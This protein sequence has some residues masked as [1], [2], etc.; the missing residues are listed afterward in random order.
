MQVA[1]TENSDDKNESNN[2][3]DSNDGGSSS[4]SNNN[5]GDNI[6]I[7]ETAH[8]DDM[9]HSIH[10][11]LEQVQHGLYDGT[12]FHRNSV[13]MV[14]AGPSASP[15]IMAAKWQQHPSLQNVLFQEYSVQTPHKQ[16]T[17][18][19]PGR[20][21]GGPDFYINVRD[22]SDVHGPTQANRGIADPCFA[23]VVSGFDVLRQIH[24][25]PTREGDWHDGLLHPVVI[26]RMRVV[27]Y[28]QVKQ[29]MIHHREE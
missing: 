23:H 3:N 26:Q 4:S 21:L 28:E 8:I 16:Y 27:S 29:H 6:I 11:F 18:G 7:I 5:N 1:F 14:Q 19:Y 12:T 9:P 24:T 2:N 17:I 13:H 20:P 10:L 15:E 22:N 25:S